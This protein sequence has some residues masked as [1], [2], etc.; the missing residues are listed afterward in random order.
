[1]PRKKSEQTFWFQRFSLKMSFQY[2]IDDNLRVTQVFNR[3]NYIRFL[4]EEIKHVTVP[5]LNRLVERG[6]N[7]A[8]VLLDDTTDQGNCV[9]IGGSPFLDL[10]DFPRLRTDFGLAKEF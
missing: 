8:C 6:H 9:W 3:V 10:L 7:L 1:M 2:A 4:Q 5:M